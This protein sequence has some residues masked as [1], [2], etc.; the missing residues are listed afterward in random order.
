MAAVAL[1]VKDADKLTLGQNLVISVLHALE[2]VAHQPPDQWLTNT[3][4]T[5]YQTLLLNS[6]RITF[7]QPASLNPV[8]LLLDLDLEHPVHDNQQVL[9]EARG[10]HKDL[11]DQP[12]PDAEITWFIDGSCFLEGRL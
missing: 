5:H 8:T 12:L 7:T 1:L 3:H 10:W 9:A 6:D 11:S 4:M 2:S